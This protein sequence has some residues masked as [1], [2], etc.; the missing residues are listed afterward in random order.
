[1]AT[2]VC[3]KTFTIPEAAAA[4][5]DWS[6]LFWDSSILFG[7]ASFTPSLAF[8]DSFAFSIDANAAQ[9]F[10]TATVD[11]NG[12]GCNCNLRFEITGNALAENPAC[13][14]AIAQLAP[15]SP[16]LCVGGAGALAVGIYDIPFS[17]PD[18][19]GSTLTFQVTAQITHAAPSYS[20]AMTGIF[21]N[22]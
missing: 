7:G 10:N 1:M 15:Y 6:T 3:E 9:A 14:I 2:S 22:V 5:A 20:I 12:P 11:Y 16:I 8:S 17:L 19:L 21:S 18:T 13:T 4:C